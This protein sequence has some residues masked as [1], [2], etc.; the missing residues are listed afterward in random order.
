MKFFLI[1]ATGATG[2]EIVKQG[3]KQRHEIT[4]LICNAADITLSDSRLHLVAG[5][6]LNTDDS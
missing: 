6:I 2:L 3:L 4:A 1:G 5:D